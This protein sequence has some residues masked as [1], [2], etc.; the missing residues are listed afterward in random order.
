MSLKI[1]VI[2]GF[3]WSFLNSFFVKGVSFLSMLVLARWLGPIEFGLVGMIAVFIGIGTSLIDSGLS[4][5]LIRT[6]DV[7]DSDFCSV[8]YMN[9][10]VGVLMYILMF[11][12]APYIADFYQQEILVNVI[13]VYCVSFIISAFSSVQLAILNKKMKFKRLVSLNLPSTLI[14]AII[15]LAM[16]Y[17]N[18]GVWS[19]VMM[20]L[21]TQFT[22]TVLL[23][24]TSEWRPKLIFSK[25]K[26]KYHY[27][28]GYKLMLSSLLEQI[29]SNSY[30]IIIGKYFPVQMLGYFERAKRFNDY[31]SQMITGVIGK[32]TYPLLV[33]LRDNSVE[34]SLI[35]KK[36]LKS[37]FF[38][39]AP[40]MLG[41]A[42][43]ARPLFEII[44]GL[45]WIPAV[46]F[47]QIL[48]IAS[49][50]YPVHAF[51]LNILKV[52]GRS[53][54]FLKLELVKKIIT[55][56]SVLIGFQFGIYGL[57]YSIVFTSFCA[58]LINTYFSSRL[59]N[60]KT[61][62]QLL[63]MLPVFVLSF[64]TFGIMN[65]TVLLVEQYSN[66]VQLLMSIGLGT[67]FYL[68][69]SLFYKKSPLYDLL[70]ALK[71]T[72]L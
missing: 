60:Y 19:I 2:S 5:S 7:N 36:M 61:K 21:M 4:S 18:Y 6:K 26:L 35:Y 54:W 27:V 15:G 28:F 65:Y 39:M 64:I 51:N 32:V 17:Y 23:W 68:S 56:I 14:G 71:K 40:L 38:V 12:I 47:F 22:L 33:E 13:R 58:L 66:S 42:A 63:D 3:L 11:F 70:R 31:P 29:F 59:I 57:T 16:G 43:I 41:G 8:F 50:F 25:E 9:I 46:P 72:K 53:D 1:K 44:L 67:V 55:I 45:E 30:N 49:M 20:Y 62:E 37:S 34:L 48:S 24:Q 52:Y 10:L 69:V